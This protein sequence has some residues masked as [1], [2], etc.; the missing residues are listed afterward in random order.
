MISCYELVFVASFL[1]YPVF[2]DQA[3]GTKCH[4]EFYRPI[5]FNFGLSE[6][7][8][9]T[10]QVKNNKCTLSSVR[11]L[12]PAELENGAWPNF[13]W[14]CVIFQKNVSGK[15]EKFISYRSISN[16]FISRLSNLEFL[17]VK[18]FAHAGFPVFEGA[19]MF[20]N[21]TCQKFEKLHAPLFTCA[22]SPLF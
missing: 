5:G 11:K 21:N 1:L 17:G 4:F 8:R 3:C 2:N 7:V 22:Y 20:F 9:E 12:A 14:H 6:R 10:K 18:K 19:Q 13:D 16:K 15:S